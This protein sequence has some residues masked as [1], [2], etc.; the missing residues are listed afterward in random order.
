VTPGGENI[1]PLSEKDEVVI[2]RSFLKAGLCFPL[3]KM[4]VEVLKRFEIYLH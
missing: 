4:M 2:C 3:Y 1:V